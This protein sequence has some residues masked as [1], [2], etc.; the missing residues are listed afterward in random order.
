MRGGHNAYCL[1]GAA[2]DQKM[3]TE[4]L[5]FIKQKTGEAV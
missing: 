5:I 2:Q 3:K 4:L 1:S